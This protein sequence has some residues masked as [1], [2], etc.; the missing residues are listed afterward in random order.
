MFDFGS[1][2]QQLDWLHRD[3]RHEVDY[4]GVVWC[5]K[6]T[7]GLFVTRR[8]GKIALQGNTAE[9]ADYVFSKRVV[10]PHMIL[11]CGTLNDR[12]VGRYADK[13]DE[14]LYVSFI[15]PV[16][17][18]K[19]AR[20]TEMQTAVG[21]QPVLTVNE[22]RDEF[23]GLGPVE[24]GDVL[25]APT[26]MA[27]VGSGGDGDGKPQSDGDVAPQPE[28]DP[29]AKFT[30]KSIPRGHTK[31]ANGMNVGWRPARSKFQRFAK[32][33]Q[34]AQN[35]LTQK[36]AAELKARLDAPSKKFQSTKEQDEARWK[37]FSEFTEAAE[38]DITETVRKINA[39]QKQ[40]V[41]GNLEAAITKAINPGDLFDIKKW[42]Q[43]T[44]NALTPVI[45]TLFEHQAV[46]ALAE[47][48][49]P[50]IQPFSELTREA[51]QRSVQ[52]I[53]ASYQ[54]TTLRGNACQ[55]HQ[56][57][58]AGR[59]IV[60]RHHEARGAGVRVQRQQPRGDGCQD[61]IVQDGEQRVEDRVAAIRR[62]EDHQ[63]VHGRRLEG[64]PILRGHG[65]EDNSD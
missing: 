21:S 23:M 39:E 30:R 11:I 63:V 33:R 42:I 40:E 17:E 57:R 56:R 18:D 25:M 15:D 35:E 22:A 31:A 48:G 26:A 10:K 64:V 16:P 43:I 19:A 46:A 62:G 54:E 52:M 20:T 34:T 50:D 45:E 13:D 41:L 38:K 14:D 6:T 44:I 5:F 27:P 47:I 3:M 4:D 36:I 53:A 49:K 24:G 8:N 12:L 2:E 1:T 32:K 9:T 59:G 37:E 51:V 60:G 58:I 55:P 28:G 7:T 65:R 29:N 61:G